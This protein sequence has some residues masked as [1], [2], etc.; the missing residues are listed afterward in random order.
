[1]ID[2]RCET[3]SS[4]MAGAAAA[5]E[6]GEA[7]S[8]SLIHAARSDAMRNSL[9]VQLEAHLAMDAAET[10]SHG[11]ILEFLRLPLDPFS[12]TTQRGHITGSA[13]VLQPDGPEFL[14]VKHRKLNRWLQPGGHVHEFDESVLATAIRETEEETG[15]SAS[16]TSLRDRILHVDVHEIPA[17]P[18]EPA[19]LHYDIRYLL[20]ATRGVPRIAE[21]EVDEAE[22]FT[23][24]AL[25][26]LDLDASLLS[27]IASATR[28]LG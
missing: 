7:G 15:H 8:R 5:L 9:R 3:A 2:G 28:H 23:E 20:T 19:H 21:G 17:R 1:M 25:K 12:R 4:R 14:L 13:I 6:N 11:K 22:W 18:G 26:K 10:A 16:L 27:A 24:E